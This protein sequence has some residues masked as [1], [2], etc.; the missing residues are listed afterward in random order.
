MIISVMT[1]KLYASWVHSLKEKRMVVKSLS[2]RLRS[3][4]NV[5]VIESDAH[6]LHQTAIL[7]V[8]FLSISNAASDSTGETIRSFIE[9]NTDAEIVDILIE[10]R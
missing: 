7:S 6:D 2:E 3:R 4:F 1:V 8:V 5:S 9:N 10:K